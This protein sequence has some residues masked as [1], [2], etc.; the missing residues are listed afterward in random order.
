MQPLIECYNALKQS[1]KVVLLNLSE[2]WLR[3]Y[4]VS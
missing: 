2:N 4:Q 3:E 1:G